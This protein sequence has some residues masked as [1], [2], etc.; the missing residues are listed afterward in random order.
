MKVVKGLKKIYKRMSPYNRE[1]LREANFK[2]E[3]KR[4]G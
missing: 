3:R 1:R 2:K 4:R